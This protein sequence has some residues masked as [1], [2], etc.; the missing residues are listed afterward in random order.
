MLA[1]EL[2]MTTLKK[3]FEI[4]KAEFSQWVPPNKTLKKHQILDLT[5]G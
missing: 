1:N 5:F 2:T 4:D 3:N